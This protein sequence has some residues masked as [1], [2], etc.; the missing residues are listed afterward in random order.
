MRCGNSWSAGFLRAEGQ[1]R[2]LAFG[3]PPGRDLRNYWQITRRY[4]YI[5]DS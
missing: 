5:T 4:A 3:V 2:L 1:L